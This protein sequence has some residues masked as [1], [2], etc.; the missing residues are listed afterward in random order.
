M[1]FPPARFFEKFGIG[2]S[3]G[4]DLGFPGFVRLNFGCSRP[5][6]HEALKRMKTAIKS[7]RG[8]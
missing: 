2:L 5:L 4:S 3:E 1:E 8:I 7:K 6:L